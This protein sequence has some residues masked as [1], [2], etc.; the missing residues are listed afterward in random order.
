[1]NSMAKL[2]WSALVTTT[3]SNGIPGF[4]MIERDNSPPSLKSAYSPMVS[5]AWAGAITH[6]ITASTS[7]SHDGR[8]IAYYRV[9]DGQRDVWIVPSKGGLPRRFTENPGNDT[10]PNWSPNGEWIAFASDRGGS[11]QLWI[12][13]VSQGTRTSEPRRVTSGNRQAFMPAWSPDVTTLAYVAIE[14]G[15][16][17]VWT[18][19]VPIDGSEVPAPLRRTTGASAH[20]VRW[21][22]SQPVLLVSGSWG[23]GEMSIR[24]VSLD[25]GAPEPLGLELQFGH[26]ADGGF[27]ISLDGKRLS[28]T[29]NKAG[30]DVWVLEGKQGSF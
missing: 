16:A 19:E 26:E 8:W 28:Y 15:A 9:T 22:P 2:G 6:A 23:D 3:T 5:C 17:D 21:H 30:G 18:V 25:G 20:R 24:C 12:A 11:N 29:S 10:Q 7:F 4:V 13:E 14:E 27:D 1:M